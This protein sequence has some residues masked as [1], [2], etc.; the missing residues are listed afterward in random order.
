MKP[1][2]STLLRPIKG[3]YILDKAVRV[4]MHRCHGVEY[5]ADIESNRVV[6]HDNILIF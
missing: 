1:L 2:P 3:R 6:P 4:L 5:D